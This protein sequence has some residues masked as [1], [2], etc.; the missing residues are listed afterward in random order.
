MYDVR[1]IKGAEYKT[2]VLVSGLAPKFNKTWE[3][4]IFG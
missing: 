1:Q 2:S 3:T 4:W